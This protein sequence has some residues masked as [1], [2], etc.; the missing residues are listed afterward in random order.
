MR[1]TSLV[2]ALALLG[3]KDSLDCPDGAPID[4]DGVCVDVDTSADH[5]G[6]CGTACAAE[7][8]CVAGRCTAAGCAAGTSACGGEC[9]DLEWDPGH[10]GA[11]DAAC[12]AGEVCSHGL[13]DLVC[14]G[15]TL[16]C[17][18]RCVDPTLNPEHCGS[19]GN[20]CADGEVCDGGACALAC[21]SG[22]VECGGGCADLAREHE[23]CGECDHACGPD[24]TCDAGACVP[25]CAGE[26]FCSGEC[27]DTATDPDHCGDCDTA[28][29]PGAPCVDG[30]CMCP[31]PEIPCAAGCLDPTTDESNCG[32]CGVTCLASQTCEDGDCVCPAGQV[33]CGDGCRDTTSDPTSCGG[34]GWVC[35]STQECVDG[36]CL[37]PFSCETNFV[38]PSCGAFPLD[39]GACGAAQLVESTPFAGNTTTNVT[40]APATPFQANERVRI[41]GTVTA[42][43]A[44]CGGSVVELQLRSSLDQVLAA[45]AV[46]APITSSSPMEIDAWGSPYACS[47][48]A[49]SVF[50]A[51]AH[52]T[53]TVERYALSGSFNT[54]GPTLD[55]PTPLALDAAG[56]ACDQV[57]G[58]L[59]HTCTGNADARQTYALT[60]PPHS[61]MAV[62]FAVRSAGSSIIGLE[63]F[64]AEGEQLC[65]PVGGVITVPGW[66][67]YAGRLR[68]NTDA[69]RDVVLAPTVGFGTGVFYQ[70]A[71]AIEDAPP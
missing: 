44:C 19:C 45:Q 39:V 9:V 26:T 16:E 28:C 23:H 48:P 18:G 5:C 59:R 31:P 6:S 67:A 21:A 60:L 71:A 32:G 2:F 70:I 3:C 34:C 10:C 25:T 41:L 69:P 12:P 36:V 11:C 33:L 52:Y 56:D 17:E 27:A 47:Q 15:G 66:V 50:G 54:G 53:F 22:L 46:I 37:A 63:A 40:Y 4:C 7:E 65:N 1:T 29:D 62:D 57:C 35:G 30:L 58:H 49:F 38:A 55:T 68:N 64:T 8:T 24:E 14:L 43:E 13:C 51:F 42:P 61:A 20:A